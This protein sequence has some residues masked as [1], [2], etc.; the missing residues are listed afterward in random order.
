MNDIK[1]LT[2]C[3][4]GELTQGRQWWNRD[5]GFGHCNSCTDRYDQDTKIGERNDCFGIKG[6]HYY[7]KE[8]HATAGVE[9]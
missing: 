2:C 8:K 4:C 7:L 6:K 5:N 3:C 1:T 9:T